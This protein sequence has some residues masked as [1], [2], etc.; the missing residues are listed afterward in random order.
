MCRTTVSSVDDPMSKG[1]NAGILFLLALP[2]TLVGSL[3]AGIWWAQRRRR[4]GTPA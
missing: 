3:A 1:L 4:A 2:F